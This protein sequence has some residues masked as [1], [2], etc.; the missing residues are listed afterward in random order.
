MARDVG[1]LITGAPRRRRPPADPSRVAF[2]GGPADRFTGRDLTPP[3]PGDRLWV[4]LPRR[5]F[6][7]PITFTC[8]RVAMPVFPRDVVLVGYY[9]RDRSGRRCLWVGIASPN[10][11][12]AS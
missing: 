2:C 4:A 6:A 5:A 9:V 11:R 12:R 1:H 3:A 10:A 7:D 8:S